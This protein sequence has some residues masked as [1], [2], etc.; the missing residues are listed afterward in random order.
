MICQ[1]KFVADV[2]IMVMKVLLNPLE[3]SIVPSHNMSGEMGT[4]GLNFT[5]R[6]AIIVKAIVIPSTE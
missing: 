1:I 5:I 2:V 3:S 6:V 4:V